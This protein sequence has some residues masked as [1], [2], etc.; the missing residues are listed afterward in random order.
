MVHAERELWRLHHE[1]AAGTYRPGPYRSFRIFDPK[2]RLISAAPFRDRVVHHALCAVVAPI[3]ERSF[4]HDNYANRTGKGAHAAIHRAQGFL[5][6]H[7]Y[8]LKA[9]IRKYFHSI[10]H[11]VLKAILRRRI[12]CPLTLALL[13][14]I[15]DNSNPQDPVWDL[16]PGDDLFTLAERRRGIPIGNLT[17]QWFANLYLDGFDHFVKEQLHARAYVR[18]VDDFVVFGHDRAWLHQVRHG[19]E[20]YL[21]GLRLVLHPHKTYVRATRHGLTFLGQQV[22][23]DHRLL[24]GENVRRMWRRT[25]RRTRAWRKGSLD[26]YT[27]EQGL[28]AWA[29]HARQA[30]THRLRGRLFAY[31]AGQGCGPVLSPRGA[32]RLVEQQCHELPGGEP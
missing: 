20:Q 31:L 18:Y 11:Q 23:H 12:A 17:S 6:Q 5:R 8:V 29:G 7:P 28:N 13:D 15:I 30:D 22:F 21:A 3:W 14:A 9:D 26:S 25:L 16:F 2:E 4:I 1:L 24:R 10:D 19:M 27:F 32:W